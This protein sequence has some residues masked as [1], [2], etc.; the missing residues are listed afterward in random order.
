[1]GMLLLLLLLLLLVLHLL[2]LDVAQPLREVAGW[3]V[4]GA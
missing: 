2:L 1:M 3:L 4:L